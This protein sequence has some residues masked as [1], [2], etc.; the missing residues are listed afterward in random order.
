VEIRPLRDKDVPVLWRINEE[1]LPGTGQISQEGIADLLVLSELALG[2]ATAVAAFLCTRTGFAHQVISCS[3][4]IE[5][6]MV[7]A[8]RDVARW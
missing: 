8:E 2:A 5:D 3:A 7:L 6:A 4:S 1:G